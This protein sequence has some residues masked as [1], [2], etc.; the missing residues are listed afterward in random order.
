MPTAEDPDPRPTED[1]FADLVLDEEFVRAATVKEPSGRARMLT[2]RWKRHPPPEAE[3]WRPATEVRRGRFGRR[4]GRA[5]RPGRIRRG[6][7]GWQTPVFVV[8]AAAVTLAALN[9]DRLRDWYQGSGDGSAS[10]APALPTAKPGSGAQQDPTVDHP[11]AGSPAEGWGSGA[12]ALALPPAQAV[13]AFSEQQV[14]EQLGL[15][16]DFLAASNLDPAV[17]AGGRPEAALA[18]LDLKGHDAA[19]AALAKPA[20]GADPTSWFSRFDPREAVQVGGAVKLQGRMSVAGDG[21]NGVLVHTD[22]T[23]VYAM[24]PGPEAGRRAASP[25]PSASRGPSAP[26]GSGGDGGAK[27]VGW[28]QP[29]A[30][31]PGNTPTARTIVRRVMTFRFYDPARY[32]ANPKKINISERSS[33]V[34]NTACQVFDGFYHPEFPQFARIAPDP[35]QSGPAVDPYDDKRAMPKEGDTGDCGTASRT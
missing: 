16:R 35:R 21:D 5:D 34:G 19:D 23:F 24:R 20:D 25:K 13:G 7:R 10:S 2:E 17:I 33:D 18:L 28:V 6:G 14:A 1:P 27:P 32:R 30:D 12:E 11:W 3:P 22:F 26:G 29:V 4:A 8:L 31:A 15:V 9:V